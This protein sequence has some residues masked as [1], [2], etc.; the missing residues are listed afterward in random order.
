VALSHFPW[1]NEFV[2]VSDEKMTPVDGDDFPGEIGFFLK[3]VVS[4]M[5]N[6]GFLMNDCRIGCTV[7]IY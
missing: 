7:Q 6:E 4:I 1:R 3:S 2:V 5:E